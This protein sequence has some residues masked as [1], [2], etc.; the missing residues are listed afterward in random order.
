MRP[1]KK[2]LKL[3]QPTHRVE[4]GAY[5]GVLNFQLKKIVN[6]VAT[7]LMTGIGLNPAIAAD[8]FNPNSLSIVEGQ[9]I[10]QLQD[11]EQFSKPGGQIAGDYR[12]DVILNGNSI[13]TKEIK[14]IE[15][16]ENNQL[17][18][19]LTKQE[20]ADWGV[21]VDDIPALRSLSSTQ[22]IGALSQYIPDAKSTLDLPQ[23]QLIISIPQIAMNQVASD[24]IPMSQW[25]NGVPA[26][27]M[28]YYYSG[29]NNWSQNGGTDTNSQYVNL[30]SGLNVG[31]WRLKNYSTYTSN[32]DQQSW[33]SIETS[34]ERGINSLKSQL[35]LGDTSTPSEIFD[36][37]QFRGIQLQSDESMLPNSMKGFAPVVRG[38]A[39]SNAEVTVKQNDYVIYQSYVSPGAFE[40]DNLNSIG[41]G[42]D[43]TVTIKEADGSERSYIVPFSSVAIMQREGQFK[44]SLTGG[45]F[46]STDK[47]HEPNFIQST[48]IYGLPKGI[49]GYVG[50]ILSEN[51]QSYAL[52]VGINLGAL[53]ALSTDV[54]QASTKNLR[55]KYDSSTGESYRFQYTKNMMATGTSVT[56]AN[57]RYSTEGYYTFTEANSDINQLYRDNK[58]NRFQIT[59]SQSLKE[60]GSLYFSVYQQ[61]YWNRSGSE[62]TMST[63]YN[64]NLAGMTYSINYNYSMSPYNQKADNQF[65]ISL[66]IP[67]GD[68]KNSA[69]L[70]TSMTTDNSG[71]TDAMIGA[72]GS[73]LEDNNLNY[74]VQ[75]SY[76]NKGAKASGNASAS[77][78]GSFGIANVGYGYDKDNQRVNYGLTGAIVAHPYG[79]T[80]A[81][82]IYDSFA[83]IRAPGADGVK[84]A[85]RTGVLTDSRGYAIVP[86][87]NAYSKNEIALDIDTLPDNVELKTNSKTVVPTRGAA[88]LANYETH[89]G[90]RLLFSVTHNGK[91]VPF[92]AM[93][94]LIGSNDKALSTAIANEN[95]DIYLSGMPERGRIQVK[96]GKSEQD[97]CIADYQLMPEHLNQ[98]LPILSV[99]CR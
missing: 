49:T 82:P 35:I 36:G 34:L 90:Y 53:G 67:L 75:Q 21:K 37:I 93:A 69:S 8:Y 39:Q 28:N 38:I 45:K 89:V 14:F 88:I 91:P 58:K 95:G 32:S 64:N 83:I 92:G 50:T 12:V 96:W 41:S 25:E 60:L 72:S 47:G 74:T 87:L 7:I 86:Y 29:S 30:R 78:R 99:D 70:N 85:N 46:K 6:A 76:G 66:S 84:V 57:Y 24:A 61:D 68:K 42:G 51:Y 10:A 62:R 3:Y 94:Q 98:H 5:N 71:Y 27:V 97:Q 48:L 19:V 13:E 55:G 43:L 65:S 1:I 44:Y 56:L 22:E 23:Q 59:L 73:L 18:P 80:L 15:D 33:Q 9:N 26:L 17:I 16:K 63:G 20:L 77:Y 31:P 2:K 54:T 4:V 52:G 79:V 40:I 81:Q 11:L